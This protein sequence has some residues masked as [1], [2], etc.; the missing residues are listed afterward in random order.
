MPSRSPKRTTSATHRKACSPGTA[1]SLPVL[2]SRPRMK[3]SKNGH[4]RAIVLFVVHVIF[5][6]HIGQWLLSGLRTGQRSTLSPI[7]P[8]ESMYALELGQLNAGFVFFILAI[9]ATL[10]FGRYFCGWGCHVVA[11]QDLCAWAMRKA[12]MR[13][14]A[15]RSRLLVWAPL[16]LGLYMFVWPTFHREVITPIIGAANMPAWLGQSAPFP[17][18]QPHFIVEDFWATFPPWYVAIPFLVIC[19]FAT[20]Y[21]LGAKGFCTY[22]CPYGG[23]FAVADKVSP[24][25]IVV[26]DNC[27][28]CGHCTAACTSNV[29]VHEEVRDY[30]MVIDPG[31]M[32]CMDCVSVC[33][34][35]AL[36]FSF[37]RPSAFV[38]PRD[39]AAKSRA[40]RRAA[41]SHAFDLSIREEIVFAGVFV[42]L[43]V[44]FRGMLG[45]IPLLMAAGLAGIGTFAAWKLWSI[46][47]KPNVRLQNL[48]LRSKGR[49]TH[50]SGIFIPATIL[51]L[52]SAAWSTAVKYNLW[53][54]D[55]LD[56]RVTVAMHTVF[57]PGYTPDAGDAANARRAV[58]HFTR[59]MRPSDGGFGWGLSPDATIRLAWMYAVLARFD[60][61]ERVMLE[62][63]LRS[64]PSESMIDDLAQLMAARGASPDELERTLEQISDAHPRLAGPHLALAQ[65]AMGRGDAQA[66]HACIV[67]GLEASSRSAR[68]QVWA[69]QLLFALGRADEGFAALSRAAELEPRSPAHRATLAM[70][71]AS[72][73]DAEQALAHMAVAAE[74]G[75]RDVEIARAHAAL[76][77]AA[78][79]TTQA[80]REEARARSLEST[81]NTHSPE[82]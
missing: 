53:R 64:T 47:I 75:Q 13:P 20:V 62:A 22:G 57:S 11:L 50:T 23:F 16:G 32:K 12:R 40:A 27:H 26:N 77:R 28:Q 15:F 4:R 6:I 65:M 21:F 72:V 9:L 33:P 5:L 54:A 10:V 76:L 74:L 56:A 79:K 30:G 18:F 39:A 82:K 45:L 41:R 43:L 2:D 73:G 49:L 19:G 81:Q 7:E 51:L 3:R 44:A 71:Y 1:V 59:A 35:E 29:R 17:G 37:A 68:H 8:S 31:C 61:A 52:A 78:G 70:A 38:K 48:Q 46:A 69:G 60:Q 80:E 36:S 67:R 25:R 63:I 14:K 34:N 42:V 55:A 66:A 24:G 58:A